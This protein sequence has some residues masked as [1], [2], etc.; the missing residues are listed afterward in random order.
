MSIITAIFG[1]RVAERA[2]N[3]F[4]DYYASEKCPPE[5]RRDIDLAMIYYNAW[6]ARRD[7]DD[8]DKFFEH[9]DV[10]LDVRRREIERDSK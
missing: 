6:F 2:G 10:Y 8:D 4:L 9:M 5:V 7:F 1:D 3:A